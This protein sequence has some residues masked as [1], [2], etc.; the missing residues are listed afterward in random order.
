MADD[1]VNLPDLGSIPLSVATASIIESDARRNPLPPPSRYM[2]DLTPAA[3]R[4]QV[5]YIVRTRGIPEAEAMAEVVAQ[6]QS[7]PIEEARR[8]VWE[9]IERS[10]K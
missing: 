7:L 8:R 5:A 4:E 6:V 2:T 10:R 1:D 9:A 3:F